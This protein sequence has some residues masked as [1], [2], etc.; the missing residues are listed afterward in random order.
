MSVACLF[1][2]ARLGCHD[3]GVLPHM[4]LML[5]THGCKPHREKV[6]LNITGTGVGVD[7]AMMV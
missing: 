1:P 5:V 4:D 3:V 2:A 7:H 6:G